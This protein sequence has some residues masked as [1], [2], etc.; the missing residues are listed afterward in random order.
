MNPYNRA[1][2]AFNRASFDPATIEFQ[3]EHVEEIRGNLPV[4]RQMLPFW[5]YCF[6]ALCASTGVCI[7]A[8]AT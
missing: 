1:L 4:Y 5:A 3:D 7:W 2:E 8:A 6:V